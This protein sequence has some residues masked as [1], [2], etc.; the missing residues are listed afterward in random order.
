MNSEKKDRAQRSCLIFGACAILEGTVRRVMANREVPPFIIAADAGWQQA[1]AY[2]VQPDLIV[3]DFDSSEKPP[4]GQG[5]TNQAQC[6]VLPCEK[7]DT[8]LH[9]AA[10]EA[11]KRGF[12]E[13]VLLGVMGGRFDQSLASLATLL[14]LRRAGA[15][16]YIAGEKTEVY[17]ALPGETLCLPRREGYYL[18]VFPAEGRADGVYEHGVVYPL[19][20]ASLRADF[21]LGVSNEFAAE[22][23]DISCE[24]G[25]L[26][27]A[28]VR[29]DGHCI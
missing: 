6:I 15:R 29:K 26:F 10:G 25:G 13:I 23:A 5:E 20:N 8:D 27:V 16:A 2:G 22:Q 9:F 4:L 21:P 14:Y 24:T 12:L 7:D 1:L 18:S 11:V 19:E 3:G 17:C 28:V